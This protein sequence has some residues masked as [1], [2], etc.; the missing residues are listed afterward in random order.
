ML[1][2]HDAAGAPGY[3]MPETSRQLLQ[4]VCDELHL[5]GA[6]AATGRSSDDTLQPVPL[7]RGALSSSLFALSS[8]VEQAMAGCEYPHYMALSTEDRTC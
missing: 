4:E 1:T 5:L 2:Q 7:Q 6:L 3:L 8:R